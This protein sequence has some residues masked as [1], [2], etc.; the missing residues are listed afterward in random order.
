[1]ALTRTGAA[2]QPVRTISPCAGNAPFSKGEAARKKNKKERK[3]NTD[4]IPDSPR[5]VAQVKKERA[6]QAIA[7]QNERNATA[8]KGNEAAK[9]GLQEILA[10]LVAKTHC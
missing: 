2:I 6:A 8:K 10:L 7:Q 5:Y 3:K 1:M 9:T 4:P